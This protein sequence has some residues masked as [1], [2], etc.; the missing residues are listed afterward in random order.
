MAL[1][2]YINLAPTEVLN[3]VTM[4]KKRGKAGR[5]LASNLVAKAKERGDK[6]KMLQSTVVRGR[7]DGKWELAGR[8]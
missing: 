3:L 4:E 1:F 8:V 5:A 2:H 6:E 7:G